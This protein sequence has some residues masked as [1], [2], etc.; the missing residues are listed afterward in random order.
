V[1]DPVTALG[2]QFVAQVADAAE[3]ICTRDGVTRAAIADSFCDL[4]GYTPALPDVDLA[5]T[6][7][8]AS[9]IGGVRRA[10]IADGLCFWHSTDDSPNRP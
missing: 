9:T 2:M 3:R 1:S 4:Y 5:L 8:A 10:R 6:A 7:L